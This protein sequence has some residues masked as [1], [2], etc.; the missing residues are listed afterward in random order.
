MPGVWFPTCER[1]ARYCLDRHPPH[2]GAL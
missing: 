2:A 1:V